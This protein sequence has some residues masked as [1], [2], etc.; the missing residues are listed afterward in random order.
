MIVPINITKKLFII[1]TTLQEEEEVEEE[2]EDYWGGLGTPSDLSSD[3]REEYEKWKEEK[4][5]FSAVFLRCC[6]K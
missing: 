1:F 6:V 3:G 2:E 4:E 5:D